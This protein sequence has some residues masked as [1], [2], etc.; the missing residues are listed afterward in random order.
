MG[1]FTI[2]VVKKAAETAVSVVVT[3]TLWFLTTIVTRTVGNL[4]FAGRAMTR[5]VT[6]PT[7]A[8]EVEKLLSLLLAHGQRLRNSDFNDIPGVSSTNDVLGQVMD[9]MNSVYPQQNFFR[10]TGVFC[11]CYA[12]EVSYVPLTMCAY[13]H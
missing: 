7:D 11:A 5:I 2:D 9:N 12:T 1:P 3:S 8:A 6:A 13:M 10:P 4:P